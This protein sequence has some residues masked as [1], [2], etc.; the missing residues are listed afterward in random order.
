MSY[1]LTIGN[2]LVDIL[3]PAQ[4]SDLAN[5][6]LE[7]GT[8]TL[9]SQSGIDG[10]YKTLK[11]QTFASGGSA[12]NTAAG[13]AK[14][15]GRSCFI[16]RVGNDELGEVFKSELGAI[17]VE[18]ICGK[19]SEKQTGK[20]IV[21]I[22]PNA[23]RTMATNLGAAEDFDCQDVDTEIISRAKMVYLEGYLFTSK[24]AIEAYEKIAEICKQN[25]IKIAL[26]LSDSFIVSNYSE[27]LI[28]FI[29][30]SVDILFANEPEATIL[31]KARNLNEALDKIN[32]FVDLA[33]ITCGQNGAFAVSDKLYKIDAMSSLKV[34]DSTGAGDQFAAGFLYEYLKSA[35]IDNSLKTAT[36]MA[37]EV[38]THY[39]GRTVA[40]K[41]E[42]LSRV[43]DIKKL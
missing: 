21:L 14:L 24:S 31:L 37:G 25:K 34:V 36:V 3:A 15:G 17:G 19:T 13:Y 22:T 4:T 26:S 5:H 20:S 8:M 33:V 10:I 43:Q 32:S 18:F 42:L 29:T 35:H 28:K 39:G 38:I 41:A 30:S 40:S 2:A 6:N 1:L 27:Q 9:Q 23:Q 12:A 11:S 7:I 16:G